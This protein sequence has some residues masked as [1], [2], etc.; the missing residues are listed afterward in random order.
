MKLVKSI[1]YTAL[2]AFLFWLAY[3]M[4]APDLQA[5]ARMDVP[6]LF[7]AVGSVVIGIPGGLLLCGWM[8]RIF[9]GMRA[10]NRDLLNL[11]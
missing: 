10:R 11:K 2:A 6:W 5:A 3:A 8:A 7:M 4:N 9:N 1:L